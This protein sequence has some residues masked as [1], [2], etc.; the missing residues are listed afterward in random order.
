MGGGSDRY[1]GG[2]EGK[3]G[4]SSDRRKEMGREGGLLRRG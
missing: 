4:C 3:G 1:I 2:E